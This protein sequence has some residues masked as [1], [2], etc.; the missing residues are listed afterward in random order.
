M[1]AQ[2]LRN[3]QEAY[4]QVY[5]LDEINTSTTTQNDRVPNFEK[6]KIKQVPGLKVNKPSSPVEEEVETDL[7]D[8][9]LE[10]LVSEGYADTN[11]AALAIMANMS[12]EWKQSI[13][14]EKRPFPFKRVEAQK[15]RARKGSVYGRDTGNEP[16][17][18]VSDKERNETR[19]FSRMH[20]ASE[21]AKREKQVADKAGRSSTFFKDTH[22]A[23]A[24]QMKKAR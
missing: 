24:P 9:L 13:V 19:R 7:F 6:P 14:E 11:K 3:L 10:Y 2:E 15:E 8:Y 4:G 16:A 12:E 17:P 20:Q 1:D 21:K 22:P 5:Q 23:S 18:N